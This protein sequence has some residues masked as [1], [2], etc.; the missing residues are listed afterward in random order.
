LISL[1]LQADLQFL[2][3]RG[4]EVQIFAIPSFEELKTLQRTVVL[5][6]AGRQ[7]T[8]ASTFILNPTPWLNQASNMSMSS[9]STPT[10]TNTPDGIRASV[11]TTLSDL[12]RS[13]KS[14]QWTR[15]LPTYVVPSSRGSIPH[16]TPDNL[17]L[18]TNI[19]YAHI[20]L[21]DFITPPASNSPILGIQ[22]S[23]HK[24]LAYP[25]STTVVFAARRA[26]PVPINSSWNDKIEINTVDGRNSLPIEVFINAIQQVKLRQQDIVISIP[27]TTE[28]PGVKRLGKMVDRTQRWLDMLLNTNVCLLWRC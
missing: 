17:H 5:S 8:A 9:L 4:R 18:H 10:S 16:L 21:E 25:E 7:T 19:P 15:P 13:K 22:T 2:N 6:L 12:A 20:G 14:F 28:S 26:N 27:D 11:S 24:Y 3:L 23:L 1:Q